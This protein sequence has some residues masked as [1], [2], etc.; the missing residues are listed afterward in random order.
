MAMVAISRDD[1]NRMVSS[2]NGPSIAG[3]CEA[4]RR[5]QL[6]Q[7]S[8]ARVRGWTDTLAAK[9]KAKLDWKA[10]KARQDEAQRQIQDAKDAARRQQMRM[11][12]LQNA[13]ALLR[14]QT[15]KMRQFRSQQRLVDTIDT[16]DAQ[17]KE[18]E[19]RRKKD[20]Q[21]EELWH[22]AVMDNVQKAEAKSKAEMEKENQRSMEL[23]EDLR[24]QRDEREERIRYQ[25]QSR[26]EEE[27]AAIQKIAEDEL[28]AEKVCCNCAFVT[29]GVFASL[30]PAP[31]VQA[32][33]EQKNERQ[34]KAKEA[35]EKNQMLL[36]QRQ[37]ERRKQELEHT[38]KC[39]EEVAARNKINAARAELEIK[40]L[41]EKQG[42]IASS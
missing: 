1:L 42:E 39:E 17:A 3:G 36:K 38:R 14:E 15:E 20:C 10:E 16:R 41:E 19:E 23:A 33:L 4:T 22:L 40:H 18:Q 31:L 2:A 28:A 26:L 12:T 25:Q 29:T 35:M 21:M 6:K 13:D 24:R 27:A 5:E 32:E 34:K 30:T 9:R 11:D 8:D 7:L 37:E